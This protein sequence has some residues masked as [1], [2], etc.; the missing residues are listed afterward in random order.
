MS[1]PSLRRGNL[2]LVALLL[3]ISVLVEQYLLATL[4]PWIGGLGGIRPMIVFL[5][6]P[7]ALPAIDW[8]PVSILFLILYSVVISRDLAR[9]TVWGALTGWWVLLLCIMAGGGVFYLIQDSLPREVIKGIDSFG[10]QADLILPYPSA[11]LIHLHGS[12]LMLIF[13]I[14]GVFIVRRKLAGP[15]VATTDTAAPILV[16]T[17]VAPKSPV[18][19]QRPELSQTLVSAPTS[20][21]R[22]APS[23]YEQAIPHYSSQRYAPSFEDTIPDHSTRRPAPSFQDTVQ[24]NSAG[25]ASAYVQRPQPDYSA[26]PPA[27]CRLT[28]PPPIAVVMP[29]PAPGIGKMHPCIVEGSLRPR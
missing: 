7:L 17:P 27:T 1:A 26:G 5:D 2:L 9:K 22:R 20:P 29:R 10:L 6:I 11:Q 18:T 8:A 13:F 28:T 21:A 25:R 19:Y 12:M 23:V 14:V 24:D 15:V 16:E 3:A 4:F